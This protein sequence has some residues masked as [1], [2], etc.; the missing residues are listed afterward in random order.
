MPQVEKYYDLSYVVV[1]MLFITPLFGFLTS[2]V[3]LNIIHLRFG[4][5]GVAIIGAFFRLAAYIII[6]LHP[7]FPVVALAYALTGFGMVLT[8]FSI[9]ARRLKACAQETVSSMLRGMHGL[10]TFEMPMRSWASSM[11]PMDWAAS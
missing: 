3:T 6:S 10:G 9:H 5:R 1:S 4:Q 8:I 2:M 7:P 11:R